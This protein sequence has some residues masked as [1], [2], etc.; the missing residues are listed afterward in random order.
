[1]DENRICGLNAVRALFARRAESGKIVTS[2]MPKKAPAP[3]DVSPKMNPNTMPMTSPI[4]VP[5]TAMIAASA[6]TMR[7]S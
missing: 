6:R 5:N 4:K 3:T 7:F 2:A 1:M